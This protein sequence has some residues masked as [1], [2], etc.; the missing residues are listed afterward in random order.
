MHFAKKACINSTKP[1][2]DVAS[3]TFQSHNS[4]SELAIASISEGGKN[5][6]FPT[7]TRATRCEGLPLLLGSNNCISE[8]SWMAPI[9][10]SSYYQP[11]TVSAGKVII[12]SLRVY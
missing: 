2:L 8:L 1:K 3:K 6:A 11:S 5:F 7:N 9:I 12:G 4:T 10:T